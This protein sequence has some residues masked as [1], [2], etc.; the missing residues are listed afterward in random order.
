MSGSH[1]CLETVSHENI[2]P[3]TKQHQLITLH[4]VGR[5]PCPGLNAMANHGFLP[6]DGKNIDLTTLRSGVAE[7]YNFAPTVFDGIFASALAFNFSTTGNASTI[8]LEDLKTHDT[9]EIDG[10]LSRNDYYFG[11]DNTYDQAIFLSVAKNL[12]LYKT[13]DNLM[14]RY[15]TVE[16]AAKA[17]AARVKD[18]MAVNPH[19][20][21]SADEKSGSPG[22]TG[23]YLLTLWDDKVGAAPKSW[24][25]AFFGESSKAVSH[26][27]I[28]L[29]ANGRR[30][31]HS[32]C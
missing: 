27:A 18:A 21:A 24:I 17:R 32:L 5:S 31:A 28:M 10:S 25:R 23:L 9:I 12:G 20:N 7:A 22:T 2:F 13:G 1:Q 6:H 29:T 15:V 30:G 14:D 19:F 11:D 26:N 4:N 8:N 16:V 3:D